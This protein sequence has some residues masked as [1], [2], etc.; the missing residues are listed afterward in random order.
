MFVGI[1]VL[2]ASGVVCVAI[3]EFVEAKVAPW[4]HFA[5]KA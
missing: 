4:R 2:A 5:L 3:L 1:L